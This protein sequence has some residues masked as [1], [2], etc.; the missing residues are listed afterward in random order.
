MSGWIKVHRQLVHHWI[1][2][3]TDY[4]KW[5]LD[6]I[7]EANHEEQKVLIKGVLFTCKRGEKLYSLDT[8]AKRWN[9]NKSKAKRFLDLLQKDEMVLLKNETVTTRL[10][11]CKYD[12][13]QDVRNASETQV[14]RK[15]NAS[16]TQVK[17]IKE[18]KELEECKEDNNKNKAEIF[19]REFDHLKITFEEVEKLKEKYPVEQINSVLDKIENYK[20][21]TSYKSLYLTAGNWLKNETDNNNNKNLK[22]EPKV[23]RMPISVAYKNATGWGDIEV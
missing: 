3:N 4:L 15:R 1:W 22:D 10:T 9:T 18:C 13:Y 17:P 14:K 7:I 12:D 21:N 8:W 2:E 19:Y 23:G 20:K 11:I 16:E 6:I 5:W